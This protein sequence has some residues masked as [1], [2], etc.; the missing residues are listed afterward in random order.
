M[1]IERLADTAEEISANSQPPFPSL[2]L[3]L[4]F[5]WCDAIFTPVNNCL[6]CCCVIVVITL[7]TQ[8]LNHWFRT[9]VLCQPLNKLMWLGMTHG[10]CFSGWTHDRYGP[11]SQTLPLELY[12]QCYQGG[13][14]CCSHFPQVRGTIVAIT[15]TILTISIT[16]LQLI[17]NKNGPDWISWLT[18]KAH[19][20]MLM[21]ISMTYLK[22]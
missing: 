16:T 12:P 8:I 13:T 21:D 11:E 7:E 20:H 19:V 4:S 10:V 1:Q 17:T 18:C 15:P 2:E 3:H 22:C 5:S 9:H 6:F 14:G